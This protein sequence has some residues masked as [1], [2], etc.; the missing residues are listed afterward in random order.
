MTRT[1]LVAAR[2]AV[3]GIVHAS[4][5]FVVAFENNDAATGGTEQT[6]ST[7]GGNFTDVGFHVYFG[8]PR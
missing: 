8:G 6:W 3:F 5:S 7:T 4:Y 2:V 1:T